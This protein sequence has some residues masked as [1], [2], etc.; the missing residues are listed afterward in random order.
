MKID[1][2]IENRPVT[3]TRRGLSNRIIL[4]RRYND[5]ELPT[6]APKYKGGRRFSKVTSVRVKD[7]YAGAASATSNASLSNFPPDLMQ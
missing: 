1:E 7:R 6:R 4:F 5:N 2:I 3:G